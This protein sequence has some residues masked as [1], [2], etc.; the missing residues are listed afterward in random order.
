MGACAFAK[1]ETLDDK[2]TE[3]LKIENTSDDTVRFV[4]FGDMGT[5][6]LTQYQVAQAIQK[7]CK[8]SGCDFALTLGDNIY[9]DGV[10]SVNDAQFQ[11]KFEKPYAELPFRFYMVLGN[12]DYRGS[13]EAQLAYTQKSKKWYL[14]LRYYDF[15]AGPVSF[16]A[17]DT[18]QPDAKQ[19]AY[20]Q[21]RLK[22]VKTPW[23][24]VF[25]HHPR[26]TNGFYHNTQSPALKT[27]LD[28]FCGQAQFYLSGHEHNKEHLKARCGT[29]YLVIG[30]GAGL[31]AS[32]PG[33]DS[34]FSRASLGF[35][36]F[37]ISPR[38]LYFEF[39]NT[40]GQVEHRASLLRNPEP[41]KP[42]T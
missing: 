11:S 12:H 17:L 10:R 5:G 1:G 3:P 34:L 9:N 16:F 24:I 30:T 4:A 36:W 8:L 32:N 22:E 40:Q 21:A 13:V 6:S 15:Q 33:A 31:R 2:P 25:G 42:D 14:P 19:L 26:Y 37:E 18:N 23:K 41:Q 35:A 7:K 27:L 39:L 20:F 38:R 29:E 28:S